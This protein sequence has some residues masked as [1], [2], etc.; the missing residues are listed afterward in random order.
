MFN[1]TGNDH[2]YCCSWFAVFI[3]VS[4]FPFIFS[5]RA[6]SVYQICS[7]FFCWV[8]V[9]DGLP[10]S[11]FQGPGRAVTLISTKSVSDLLLL[12]WMLAHAHCTVVTAHLYCRKP[13]LFFLFNCETRSSIV[14]CYFGHV[15][16]V[17]SEPG[18]PLSHYNTIMWPDASTA[19]G[20]H[21]DCECN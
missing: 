13:G 14:F 3:V 1:F 16:V 20:G 7:C 15:T 10:R 4:F 19:E 18:A 6:L 21:Q 5:V 9:D 11:H 17:T 8:R 2:Y 12:I